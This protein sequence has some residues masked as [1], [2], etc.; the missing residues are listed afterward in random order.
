MTE[1]IHAAILGIVQGI[2]E[3]LPIS[4]S[5]HLVIA[6]ALLKQYGDSQLPDESTTMTIALHAGTLLSILVVYRRDLIPVLKDRRLLS[7]IVLA[8]IPV[9]IIGLLFK[10]V[11]EAAFNTPLLAGCALIVTALFL[12]VGRHLQQK[13][14]ETIENSPLSAGL[15]GIFQAIAI[16][17]GI[18]RSGSTI[19]AALACGLSRE[20]AARFS[21]LIAI[22]AIGGVSIVKAKDLLTGEEQLDS[23][24]LP[25]AL[26]TL[27]A[28]VVGVIALSWLLRIVTADRLHW[29]ATYCIIVG[30]AT[31]AWQLTAEPSSASAAR[32]PAPAAWLESIAAPDHG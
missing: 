9:G 28:F 17:P 11:V 13:K 27:I 22:P 20:Q 4:S 15:I 21:F 32:N 25:I 24:L 14:S 29:F 2:A 12:L 23:N 6:G 16:V 5:G 10:D 3:F 26:G 31:I 19:A 8:T 30:L 7:L 18:S 1:Y